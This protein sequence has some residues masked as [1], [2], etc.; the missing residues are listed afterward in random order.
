M[1]SAIQN[2]EKNEQDEFILDLIKQI[3]YGLRIKDI[4]DELH[5]GGGNK[6]HNLVRFKVVKEKKPKHYVLRKDEKPE[7]GACKR[8]V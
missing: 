2:M 8:K 5:Q 7:A 4:V 1:P 6:E 3:R